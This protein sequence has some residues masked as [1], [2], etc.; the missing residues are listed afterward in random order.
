MKRDDVGGKPP[1]GQGDMTLRTFITAAGM[2]VLATGT[3][4]G[5]SGPSVAELLP[6][7]V[8]QAA[9]IAPGPAGEDHS[10]H[11]LPDE[12]T[13]APLRELNRVLAV[14]VGAFPVG[15]V[16]LAATPAGAEEGHHSVSDVSA[17]TVGNNRLTLGV[18]YQATT[19]ATLD[20]L[21]LRSSEIN[22]YLPHR[23]GVDESDRDMMRQVASIRLNRKVAS[24]ALTYGLSDRADIGVV[25]PVVQVAADARVT[26]HIV[27]TATGRNTGVHQFDPLG[28]ANRTLP[29]YCSELES[30]PVD[31]ESLQCHGSATARGIGDIVLRGRYRLTGGEAAV[32]VG[33]D[34]RLPTGSRDNFIGLG[35]FQVRPA[36]MVSVPAGRFIPRAR[37]DYTWSE[38]ELSPALGSVDLEVPDEIGAAVGLDAR[39][40]GRAVLA[41]DVNVRRIDGIRELTTTTLEFPSRGAGALPSA[42]YLGR[43]ALATGDARAILLTNTAVGLRVA[44]PGDVTAQM[45]VVVP[46]GSA[47]LQ[48]GPMA[49]FSVTR[50]Y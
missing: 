39:F 35:A 46:V 45:S 10:R 23:A 43:R 49:V 24:F 5:Q 1:Q 19:F 48:P 14:Q 38:G 7:L 34:V 3:A 2:L 18:G 25:V 4:S 31:P 47:G 9:V 33:T 36:V 42:S 11:F 50:G 26:S 28:G 16:T 30:V 8:E 44:M 41:F 21:D 32:A 20:D 12:A 27:R 29:R 15:P 13:L 37:V 17:F 6:T 22:L 40:L